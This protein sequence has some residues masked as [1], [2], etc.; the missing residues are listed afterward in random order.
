MVGVIEGLGIVTLD[1]A[2]AGQRTVGTVKA[3]ERLLDV[4]EMIV[5][6]ENT[7][8]QY[9]KLVAQAE[10]NLSSEEVTKRKKL[11]ENGEEVPVLVEPPKANI[12]LLVILVRRFILK[13]NQ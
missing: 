13:D 6:E 12:L 2:A 8:Q 3:G 10:E 7:Y 9:L 1:S 4:L 11:Q 5:Q